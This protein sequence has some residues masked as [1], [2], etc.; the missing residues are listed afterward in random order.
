MQVVSQKQ[1]ISQRG[2]GQIGT[3]FLKEVSTAGSWRD[4]DNFNKQWRA[5][6]ADLGVPEV[7][8][9][10]FRKSVAT[11]IDDAGMS[12]RIG[13]DQLGHAKV[14]MT[15]D[16]YMRRGKVHVEVAA[17]MDAAISGE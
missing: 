12:A 6:R 1:I 15:Q 9:H 10:S 14:S 7:T 8:S 3:A 5:I 13:A 17:V 4:P 16:K 11:Y 2:T